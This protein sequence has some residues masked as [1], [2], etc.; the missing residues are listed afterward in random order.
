MKKEKKKKEKKFQTKVVIEK[1][2]ARALFLVKAKTSMSYSM[3]TIRFEAKTQTLVVTDGKVLLAVTIKSTGILLPFNLET[4]FYDVLGETLL[5][6]DRDV[7]HR[8]P[9]YKSVMPQSE[10]ICAGD[11]L[12]GIIDCMI[13]QQ[14]YLDIWKYKNILN[15]LD[16]HFSDWVFTNGGNDK[17]VMMEANSD[18]YNVKFIIMPYNLHP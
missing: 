4:G 2:L 8:F 9:D 11:M 3:D 18:K 10:K 6:S 12:Y 5:K 13:K 15:I 16:K 7:N 1:W 17:P 14:V